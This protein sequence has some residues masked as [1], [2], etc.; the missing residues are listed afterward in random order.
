MNIFKLAIAIGSAGFLLGATPVSAQD[1]PVSH[2]PNGAR[3]YTR[4]NLNDLEATLDS[5]LIAV[6]SIPAGSDDRTAKIGTFDWSNTS[7]WDS[8]S[9]NFSVTNGLS[10]ETGWWQIHFGMYVSAESEH[11]WGAS[12]VPGVSGHV[13]NAHYRFAFMLTNNGSM[14]YGT[15]YYIIGNLPEGAEQ[16]FVSGSFLYNQSS[17]TARDIK[18]DF[19]EAEAGTDGAIQSFYAAQQSADNYFYAL[20]IS[21]VLSP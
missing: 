15:P 12:P 13:A 16:T 6:D 1:N 7:G 20:P 9:S 11:D 10:L 18:V 5:L 2:S 3:I 21:E 17:E 8:E 14:A 4:L 19:F